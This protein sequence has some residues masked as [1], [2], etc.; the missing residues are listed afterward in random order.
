[1][2]TKHKLGALVINMVLALEST[3][4]VSPQSCW[5]QDERGRRFLPH[6][7]VTITED[8]VGPVRYTADDYRRILRYA[9]NCQ[10]IR[11]SL[12]KLGGWPGYEMQDGY[13][14]QLDE[15]VQMGREAGLKAAFKMTVYGIRNFNKEKGWDQLLA[16]DEHQ[17]YLI[18]T[19]KKLWTRYR[20]EPSVFGYDL[21]N[22]PFRGSLGESYEQVTRERL[23]PLYRKLID[24]LR[25][26]SPDKWAIY[27]PLLLDIADR[28][29]GKL[30][31][32][33]MD[34]PLKCERIIF[35]PHGYF[36]NVRMHEEAVE[37]HLQEAALSGARLMMGEW[38]RQT[39]EIHDVSL[40][41][42]L[43]YQL[44]YA[45]LA[46]LFDSRH[47]GA[48]KPWFTGTRRPGKY[49]WSIFSDSAAVGSVERKYIVDVIARP[50]PLF[51]AGNVI[52]FDYDFAARVLTVDFTPDRDTGPSEIFIGE[53]R[54]YPDGFT[55]VYNGDIALVHEPA[56]KTPPENTSSA[57]RF[58]QSSQRLIVARWPAGSDHG[59][60]Q[61]RPGVLDS[62]AA[63]PSPANQ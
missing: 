29:P 40:A 61:I 12:A 3:V 56:P 2:T 38:G 24:Q 39:Y 42:Q 46:N 4:A 43:K 59:K 18:E 50:F 28:G 1:M 51:M 62:G 6:G 9:A 23:V 34:I 13:L 14:R 44:L 54:H 49:T 55:V 57:F 20:T 16:S 41:E 7:Y 37:R 31:M 53:N 36:P 26:I 52:D 11:L 19:W 15:M 8:S 5:L 63:A 33:P 22:E 10:V 58:D 21:L 45:D 60:L 17:R 35:A 30:P 25:R 27:Q 48:I 32:A 47:M